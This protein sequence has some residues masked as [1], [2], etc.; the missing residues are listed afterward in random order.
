MRKNNVVGGLALIAVAVLLVANGLGV[1]PEIPWLQALVS[2]TFVAFSL[3]QI[4]KRHF[5]WSMISLG[6]VAWIWDEYLGIE[7]ITPFPLLLAAGLLGIGLNMMFGKKH[8]VV[9][10]T[11]N[12]ESM[13]IDE[14]RVENWEDGRHVTLENIFKSTSKY[15]NSE[16][17]SSAEFQNV[18][19]SANV[20]FNNAIIAGGEAQVDVENVFGTL[21]LYFPATWRLQVNKEAVFGGVK[22]YG[23]PCTDP[24]APVIR[25]NAE[26]VFGGV[27]I[28]FE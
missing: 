7:N 1:W 22:V 26:S 25:M 23:R 27:N 16:A 10:I 9:T 19:G 28:Y 15:V 14:A 3:R 2:I 4:W 12:G 5:F 24:E 8:R 21:N 17:F 13:C 20:Y 6:C 18:F 11:K